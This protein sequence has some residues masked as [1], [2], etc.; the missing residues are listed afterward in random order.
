[1][2]GFIPFPG[3]LYGETDLFSE[4]QSSYSAATVDWPVWIYE[5][6]FLVYEQR[7]RNPDWV[8]V[9]LSKRFSYVS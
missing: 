3:H 1:M 9:E 6:F 2:I 5:M 7:N 4:M 8:N